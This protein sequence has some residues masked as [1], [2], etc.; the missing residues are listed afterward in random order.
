[1]AGGHVE[2][3]GQK[4]ELHPFPQDEPPL[5]AAASVDSAETER[6]RI[7]A[8]SLGSQVVCI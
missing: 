1:M 8:T 7:P 5:A 4:A 6:N 2:G 3:P